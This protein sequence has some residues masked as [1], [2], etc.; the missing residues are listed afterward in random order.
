[1]RGP[2]PLSDR[3]FAAVRAGVL[4]KIGRRRVS[5][6]RY[7]VAAAALALVSTFVARVPAV[8]PPLTR[9]FA[10]PS[11]HVVGR[12]T[13]KVPEGPSPRVSGE[14]VAEGRMRGR[15]HRAKP[16]AV[17]RMEIQTADPNVRI[18]WIAN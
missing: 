2:L 5:V 18:I 13:L 6:W 4:A 14:K 11:P 3:D 15:R 16:P 10:P 17:A 9:R 1:M 7:A 12:G 8:A